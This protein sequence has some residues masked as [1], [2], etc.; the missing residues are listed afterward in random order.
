MFFFL[1]Y[2]TW[3]LAFHMLPMA[4]I[5]SEFAKNQLMLFLREWYM[6]PNGQMPAYEFALSDVN[7]PVHA[8]ACHFVYKMTGRKGHRDELFLA[9]CFQK[10][11]LNFTWYVR[12]LFV[13]PN[14][15]HDEI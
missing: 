8:M 1:Q 7:P 12:L 14:Q 4:R 2:A 13:L 3:D 9:R 5:D 10:L 15:E 6:A 11:L